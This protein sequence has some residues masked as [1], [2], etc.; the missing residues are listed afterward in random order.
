MYKTGGRPAGAIILV[1][2]VC[3]A[4]TVLLGRWSSGCRMLTGNGTC[5][6]RLGVRILQKPTH[7]VQLQGRKPATITNDGH[8]MPFSD[9]DISRLTELGFSVKNSRQ[10]LIDARGDLQLAINHLLDL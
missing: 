4:A 5:E 2:I 3:A 1:G 8:Q 10:A 6:T 7:E 9:D